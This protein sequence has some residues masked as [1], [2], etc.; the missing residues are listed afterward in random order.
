MELIIDIKIFI[1]LFFL[2]LSGKS[3][4]YLMIFV[5]TTIHELG[6]I[7][8]GLFCGLKPVSIKIMP[9]GLNVMFQKKQLSLWKEMLICFMGPLTNIII[10]CISAFICVNNQEQI[11]YTNILIGA[12]NLLPIIP[13]DGGRIIKIWLNNK[14]SF[15][16]TYKYIKVISNITLILLSCVGILMAIVL[17]NFSLIAVVFFM[18][19]V[20]FKEKQK[21]KIEYEMY[22]FLMEKYVDKNITK[23][24]N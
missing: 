10:A 8:C 16:M 9:L 2:I 4:F 21:M 20:T 11:V 24:E 22:L 1:L 17:K 13:L 19:F 14:Y 7:L 5:F 12:F 6:H 15:K 23:W 3:K 18:Y